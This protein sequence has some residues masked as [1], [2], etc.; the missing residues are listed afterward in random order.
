MSDA[1]V[2]LEL[3]D[4][5][6]SA[7]AFLGRRPEVRDYGLLESALARPMAS[8]FGEDAYPTFHGKAAALLSSLVGNHGLVDGNKRLGLVAVRLFYAMNGYTFEATD[9]EK[10]DL[11]MDIAA[12]RLV[13]VAGIAERLA[14]LTRS[15]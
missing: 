7:E 5:L 14:A 8:V 13:E 1:V 9:D 12:G 6:A 10:F 2:Y 3:D 11:I 15:A 4:L